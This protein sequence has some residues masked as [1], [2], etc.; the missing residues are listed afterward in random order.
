VAR[1]VKRTGL[2]R[3][4]LIGLLI[5]KHSDTIELPDDWRPERARRGTTD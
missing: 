4:D 3:A 2:T 5:D 1:A